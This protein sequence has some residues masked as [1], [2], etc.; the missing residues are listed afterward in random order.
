MGYSQFLATTHNAAMNIV[1]QVSLWDDGASFGYM[2]RC[3]T[4]G[5]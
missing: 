3:V 4:A 2:P 5:F 1:K